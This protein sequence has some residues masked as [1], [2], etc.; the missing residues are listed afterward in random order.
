MPDGRLDI[1]AFV[2]CHNEAA[3]LRTCLPSLAFCRELIVVDRHSSDD[4]AATARAAGATVILHPPDPPYVEAPRADLATRA[5]CDWIL[6]A[7]PD[8]VLPAALVEDI[9]RVIALHPNAGMIGLPF[10]YHFR[11]RPLRHSYWGRDDMH[12]PRLIHRARI[13]LLPR[14]HR[15]IELRD[16]FE[17]VRVPATEANRIRHDWARSYREVLA[18]H[19]RHISC[20]DIAH[21]SSWA[22]GLRGF[23]RSYVGD[24]GWTGGTTGFLLSLLYGH[25]TYRIGATLR[26]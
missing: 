1:T 22:H 21:G 14:I 6:F 16:G 23:W 9:R 7:D 26:R 3:A 25:Y 4:S 13:N 19:R 12:L 18:K 8:E 5:Q 10:R 20:E 24:R 2:V 17:A 11:G 15:G